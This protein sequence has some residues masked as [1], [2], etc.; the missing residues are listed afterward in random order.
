MEDEIV[1]ICKKHGALTKDQVKHEKNGLGYQSIR[2]HQCK[3]DKD[4]R[5]RN[6]N[7]D[8]HNESAGKARKKS[9]EDYKLGLTDIEPKANVWSRKD[10]AENPEKHREWSRKGRERLGALR[11]IREITRVRGITLEEYYALEGRQQ[12]K[13]AICSNEET[14]KNRSGITARL[15]LDHNHTTGTVRELLCHA[16]NQVVGHSRESVDILKKAIS[17]LEAHQ[18][19]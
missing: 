3:I 17:Y 16:C 9:R 6:A 8:K 2:C 7:R 1:K 5:W 12:G 13:C 4:T 14:R 18:N 11:N 10:R 15:C 19:N